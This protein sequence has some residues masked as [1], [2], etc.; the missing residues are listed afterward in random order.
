MLLPIQG[1]DTT[2][3]GVMDEGDIIA[4]GDTIAD[5][6]MVKNKSEILE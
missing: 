4:D 3:E 2:D 5:E 6:V 1:E